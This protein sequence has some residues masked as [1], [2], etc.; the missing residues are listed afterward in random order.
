MTHDSKG[1]AHRRRVRVVTHVAERTGR[2]RSYDVSPPFVPAADACALTQVHSRAHVRVL[3]DDYFAQRDM[4]RA[5]NTRDAQ[6]DFSAVET[7]TE[8]KPEI[9]VEFVPGARPWWVTRQA[10]ALATALLATLCFR[11]AFDARCGQSEY[12]FVKD[13]IGWTEDAV[14]EEA[15]ALDAEQAAIAAAFPFAPTGGPQLG[16]PAL[17]VAGVPPP[18]FVPMGGPPPAFVPM[19]GPPPGAVFVPMGGPPPPGA[20]AFPG[21]FAG[22]P[23]PVAAAKPPPETAD[24]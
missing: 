11:I 16:V 24:A 12:A 2:F 15:R 20:P 13:A 19:G 17:P 4:W 9:L 18:A 14:S 3:F 7:V 23:P 21:Q 1:H 8:M 22:G 10:F 5:A 6:Q